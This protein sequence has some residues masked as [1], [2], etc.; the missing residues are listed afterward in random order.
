[1]PTVA[2]TAGSLA[3]LMLRTRALRLVP[4]PFVAMVLATLAV[5]NLDLPVETIGSR[6]G[7]IPSSLPRPHLPAI[8]WAEMRE[9]VSPS[10]TIALFAAIES[11]L[12]AVVADDMIGKANVELVAQGVANLSSPIFGGIPATGAI[13]RTAKKSAPEGVRRW[14]ESPMR[15]RCSPCSC[16]PANGAS[17]IPLAALVAILVMVAFH[18]SDR[19]SFA[20][21]S[22]R[23]RR[24][25]DHI[26]ADG[27]RRSDRGPA[28]RCRRRVAPVH[29]ADVGSDRTS[30]R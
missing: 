7:G 12:S 26:R 14:R 9:L 13:A 27:V 18:M 1:M 8:P 3:V 22:Q 2:I 5:Q 28:G 25:A 11:L 15:S 21:L 20:G 17:Q 24:S 10:L 30:K 16:L 4:A 23:R 6:F 19:R 29:Q